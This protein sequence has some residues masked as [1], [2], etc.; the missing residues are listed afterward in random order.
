MHKALDDAKAV[1]LKQ[2]T[3]GAEM[4]FAKFLE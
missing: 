1:D 3:R 2:Y 4:L